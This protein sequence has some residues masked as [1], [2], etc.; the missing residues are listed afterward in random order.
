MA[1]AQLALVEQDTEAVVEDVAI[2]VSVNSAIL[3]S[4]SDRKNSLSSL[5]LS[6]SS[7]FIG[8]SSSLITTASLVFWSE[9]LRLSDTAGTGETTGD[10]S[11]VMEFEGSSRSSQAPSS[12]MPMVSFWS[13]VTYVNVLLS[14]WDGSSGVRSSMCG[15]PWRL[16]D[17]FWSLSGLVSG[18]PS[19]N[20]AVSS[21]RSAASS[22]PEL[23]RCVASDQ[24]SNITIA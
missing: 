6:C 1:S 9:V 14:E 10:A 3:Y 7:S 20:G 2:M 19:L 18:V 22:S 24:N 12:S 8:V 11:G 4:S 16:T 17:A 15:S 21:P 13:S 5:L 23:E